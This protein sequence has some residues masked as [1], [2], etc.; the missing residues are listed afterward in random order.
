MQL[1]KLSSGQKCAK[2]G[3]ILKKK[4]VILSFGKTFIQSPL[5]LRFNLELVLLNPHDVADLSKMLLNASEIHQC[6]ENLRKNRVF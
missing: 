4:S 6:S 3:E 1:T 2:L 5:D